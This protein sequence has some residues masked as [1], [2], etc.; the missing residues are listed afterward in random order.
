MMQ[1]WL[2]ETKRTIKK[3]RLRGDQHMIMIDKEEKMIAR[4]QQ[5]QHPKINPADE[6]N[7][8]LKR[9]STKGKEQATWRFRM[10]EW[11]GASFP[12]ALELA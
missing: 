6:G 1:N 9:K 5:A 11:C 4:C 7:I 12:C 2:Q 10:A 8:Y 3:V